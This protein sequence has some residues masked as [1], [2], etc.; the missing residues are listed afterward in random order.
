MGSKKK[1]AEP[2]TVEEKLLW[3]RGMLGDAT[4]QSLL[5]TFVYMNGLYFARGVAA[6]IDSCNFHLHRSK[7]LRGKENDL[8]LLYTEDIITILED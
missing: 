3:E 4:L 5:D 6:S 1:Q 7:L 2:L 8:Y